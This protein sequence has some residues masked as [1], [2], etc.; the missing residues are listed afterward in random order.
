MYSFYRKLL[1]EREKHLQDFYDSDNASDKE[2][3]T[4]IDKKAVES[5]KNVSAENNLPVL[6][7]LE[8]T[9]SEITVTS[10]SNLSVLEAPEN[11]NNETASTSKDVTENNIKNTEM[12]VECENLEKEIT[13]TTN[14]EMAHMTDDSAKDANDV[15]NNVADDSDISTEK[16]INTLLEKYSE[17]SQEDRTTESKSKSGIREILKKLQGVHVPKIS[18]GENGLIDLTESTKKTSAV[19]NLKER[20]FKHISSQKVSKEKTSLR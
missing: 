10:E 8:N 2:D 18:G 16:R 19:E 3:D 12:S 5:E 17:K 4:Q 1:K 13:H 20:F 9:N 14:G 11:A 15:L 6:E 7:T